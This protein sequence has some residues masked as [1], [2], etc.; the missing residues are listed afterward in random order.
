MIVTYSFLCRAESQKFYG[1]ECSDF[2]VYQI[3]RQIS[4]AKA[5]FLRLKIYILSSPFLT[6]VYK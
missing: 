4:C 6:K 1:L 2:R 5:L 3:V